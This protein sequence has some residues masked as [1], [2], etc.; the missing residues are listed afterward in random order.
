[1]PSGYARIIGPPGADKK[2]L[3]GD[4][5]IHQYYTISGTVCVKVEDNDFPE[6]ITHMVDLEQLLPEI[7]IGIL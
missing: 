3:K 6:S 5:L 4:I 7:N 1:M 2:N